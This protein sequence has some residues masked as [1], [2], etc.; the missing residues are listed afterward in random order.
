MDYEHIKI[1]KK[2]DKCSLPTLNRAYF[3]AHNFKCSRATPGQGLK[4]GFFFGNG[5]SNIAGFSASFEAFVSEQR[6]AIAA[7]HELHQEVER[8]YWRHNNSHPR[9]HYI[10]LLY[11]NKVAADSPPQLARAVKYVG[12]G[13][14]SRFKQHYTLAEEKQKLGK[15]VNANLCILSILQIFINS[16]TKKSFSCSRATAPRSYRF[17]ICSN[18][19]PTMMKRRLLQRFVSIASLFGYNRGQ[20]SVGN[21][22]S[23]KIS[24]KQTSRKRLEWTPD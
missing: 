18:S 12:V 24:G 20:F 3:V 7:G 2:C 22:L 17:A 5:R 4:T 1:E 10:Y 16:S 23:N 11:N 9:I 15:Q 13:N 14:Y 21:S 19:R 6:E 8:L